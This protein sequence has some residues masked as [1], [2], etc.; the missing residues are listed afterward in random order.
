MYANA[1]TVR[2]ANAVFIKR[3]PHPLSGR[4]HALHAQKKH[5]YEIGAAHVSYSPSWTADHQHSERDLVP[6]GHRN[7]GPSR[8]RLH[9]SHLNIQDISE[10]M[11]AVLVKAM[12]AL[13][14]EFEL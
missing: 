8:S 6:Y 2:V 11:T 1:Q 5:R 7:P 14:V 13:Q 10:G 4:C 12:G 3:N 9:I